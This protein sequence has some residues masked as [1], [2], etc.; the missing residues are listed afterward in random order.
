MTSFAIGHDDDPW[1]GEPTVAG[2]VAEY[3][4]YVREEHAV[5]RGCPVV[6]SGVAIVRSMLGWKA[7]HGDGRLEH[8]TRGHI[9]DYLLHYLPTA[10]VS[11]MLLPDAPTCAKDLVYFLEDRGCLVGDDVGVLTEATDAVFYG[12]VRP[13]T[14]VA[15][16]STRSPTADRLAKRKAARQ[17][18][19]RN[20]QTR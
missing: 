18:R 4:E 1:G 9:R 11:R 7:S 8:W 17:A 13:A 5:C 20:R 16:R 3:A 2:V 19:R 14:E 6:R 10:N 15:M 12:Y